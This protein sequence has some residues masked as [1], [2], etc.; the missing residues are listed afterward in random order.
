MDRGVQSSE[1]DTGYILIY[2]Y[3]HIYLYIKP[4]VK[5]VKFSSLM[6]LNVAIKGVVCYIIRL[7][8]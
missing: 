4:G 5:S 6:V 1:E 7:Q 3:I 2:V 8:L